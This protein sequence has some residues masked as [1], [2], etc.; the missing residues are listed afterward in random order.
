MRSNY[1][2]NKTKYL[3]EQ[4]LQHLMNI[5]NKTISRDSLLLRLALAT[6]ARAN[7]LLAV[8]PNDLDDRNKTVFIRGLKNSNDREIPLENSLYNSLKELASYSDSKPIF[9]IGYS[10]LVA[11]WDHYRPAN[12]KFH[13]LRHTFAIELFKRTKDLNLVKTA[14]GHR[15]IQNTMVYADYIYRTQELRKLLVG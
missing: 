9:G 4:E 15:N 8:S 13:S 12:K 5:L 2:I 6:G 11:I 3:N 10:R 1:Q 7:E 14:L